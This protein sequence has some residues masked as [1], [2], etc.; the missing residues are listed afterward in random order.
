MYFTARGLLGVALAGSGL[1]ASHGEA[2]PTVHVWTYNYAGAA[3]ETVAKAQQEVSRILTR[4]GVNIEWVDCPRTPGERDSFPLCRQNSSIRPVV[5]RIFS[6]RPPAELA[7]SPRVSGRAY[8]D[9]NG[10]GYLADVYT[11]G[12][13]VL[14]EASPSQRA[15]ILGHL[16]AHELGHIFLASSSHSRRGIMRPEWD[17]A[18]LRLALSGGLLFNSQQ[19][20]RIASNLKARTDQSSLSASARRPRESQ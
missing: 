15:S 7:S 3:P 9:D 18:D 8:L 4:I 11:A 10:N 17:T 1:A 14:A 19:A 5:L 2:G 16:I 12:A 6:G 20:K 13:R